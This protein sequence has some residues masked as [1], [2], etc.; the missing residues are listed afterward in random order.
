MR[1]GDEIKAKF[2]PLVHSIPSCPSSSSTV[3]LSRL[4]LEQGANV[5]SMDTLT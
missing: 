3:Y 5:N 2:M 1:D 4:A